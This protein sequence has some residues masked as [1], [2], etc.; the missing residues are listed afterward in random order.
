MLP[1][2]C[3][4]A[5]GALLPISASANPVYLTTENYT[6]DYEL[7]YGID[8]QSPSALSGR[9]FEEVF[10]EISVEFSAP[11]LD[12]SVEGTYQSQQQSSDN[13]FSFSARSSVSSEGQMSN[14]F[15][16]N[17]MHESG[18]GFVGMETGWNARVSQKFYLLEFL[19]TEEVLFLGNLPLTN[20]SFGP[21]DCDFPSALW[22][23]PV[24]GEEGEVFLSGSVLGPGTYSYWNGNPRNPVLGFAFDGFAE[25]IVGPAQASSS[26]FTQFID[27]Q[28]TTV[29]VP[30]PS[31]LVLSLGGFG[32]MVLARRRRIRNVHGDPKVVRAS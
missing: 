25:V 3:F 11:G 28:F 8:N 26:S 30:T 5:L 13:S 32:L 21:E 31:A 23:C 17:G 1:A 29:P 4:L 20:T 10:P 22:G 7:M 9:A 2:A 24:F 27:M 15:L 6:W 18:Y 19:V 14:V 12:L 16:D